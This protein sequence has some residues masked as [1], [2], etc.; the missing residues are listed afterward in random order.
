MHIH[1]ADK[2]QLRNS[3]VV[4]DISTDLHFKSSHFQSNKHLDSQDTPL[5]S[6]VAAD[7]EYQTYELPHH[8]KK[9]Q[10]KPSK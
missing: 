4:T 3:A 8:G 2:H 5:E 6:L 7:D 10:R 9:H 1:D